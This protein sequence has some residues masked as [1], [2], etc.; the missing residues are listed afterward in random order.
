MARVVKELHSLQF[1]LL[2]KRLSTNG[3]N[4]VFA[5]PAAAGPHLP[6]PERCKAELA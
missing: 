3:M 2:F 1:Y 6:T 5:F 4:R